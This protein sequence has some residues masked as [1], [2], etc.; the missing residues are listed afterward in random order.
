MSP[1]LGLR[2]TSGDLPTAHAPAAIGPPLRTRSRASAAQHRAT[3]AACDPSRAVLD[4]PSLTAGL[5][6][7]AGSRASAGVPNRA[8][9]RTSAVGLVPAVDCRAP[10]ELGH[11]RLRVATFVTAAALEASVAVVH[12]ALAAVAAARAALLAVAAAA[13]VVAVVAAVS[14]AA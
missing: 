13:L 11:E 12:A 1:D 3:A 4:R 6:S 9:P 14:L 10:A 7:R 8:C 5:V 2:R